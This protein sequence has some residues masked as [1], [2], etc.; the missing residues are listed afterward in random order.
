MIGPGVQTIII[1][2]LYQYPVSERGEGGQIDSRGILLGLH[3]ASQLPSHKLWSA[4]ILNIIQLMHLYQQEP[5]PLILLP[6][7][8]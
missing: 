7:Y 5:K 2:R 1:T 6:V 8:S 4:L 3:P